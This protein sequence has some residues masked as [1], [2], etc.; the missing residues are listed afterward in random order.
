MER[1]TQIF[2]HE[3]AVFLKYFDHLNFSCSGIVL[4]FLKI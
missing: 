3:S 2:L 4:P 1:L